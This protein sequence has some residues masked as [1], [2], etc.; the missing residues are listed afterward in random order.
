MCLVIDACSFHSVFSLDPTRSA[1]F[2]PIVRWLEFGK[3][4]LIYGGTKYAKEICGSNALKI[5]AE[6]DRRGRLV[7]FENSRV[8]KLATKMKAQEPSKKFNDEHLVALVALSK[9]CVVCTDEEEAIPFLKRADFYPKKV[10][11]PSIYRN[12][13]HAHMCCNANVIGACKD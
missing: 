4:K 11:P 1:R 7:R 10:S 13:N 6:L 9:C 12:E 8:D 5:L 3:G 2:K